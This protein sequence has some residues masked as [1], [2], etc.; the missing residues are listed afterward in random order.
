MV[1]N[2]AKQRHQDGGAN[3][4]AQIEKANYQQKVVSGKMV[5]TAA[6]KPWNKVVREVA[7]LF[8]VLTEPNY[9][10]STKLE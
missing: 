7:S 4:K 2:K 1:K 8:G 9:L 5:F 3:P 10:P 6:R